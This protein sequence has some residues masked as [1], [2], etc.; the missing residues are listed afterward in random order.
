MHENETI[1]TTKRTNNKIFIQPPPYT[2]LDFKEKLED[3]HQDIE[4]SSTLLSNL[5]SDL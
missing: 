3:Q 4:S 1:I 5:S 2:I